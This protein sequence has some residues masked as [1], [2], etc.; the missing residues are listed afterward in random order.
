[1]E[2]IISDEIKALELLKEYDNKV[3]GQDNS[4]KRLYAE[5]CDY[6]HHLEFHSRGYQVPHST[7]LASST[8]ANWDNPYYLNWNYGDYHQ[9]IWFAR[10][11]WSR[12][13]GEDNEI[14]AYRANTWKPVTKVP[15]SK[16]MN[17][18]SKINKAS[19]FAVD[20]SKSQPSAKLSE[21]NSLFE[22]VV[23][24]YPE[25]HSVEQY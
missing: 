1:M 14:K 4:H 21:E 18:L 24:S 13:P 16:V 20:F 23:N 7:V 2:E 10:L 25:Y 8:Y 6:A 19:D 17:V 9:N 15:I 22:Y 11:I 3:G 12:R 5:M